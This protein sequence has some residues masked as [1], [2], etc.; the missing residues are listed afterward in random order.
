MSVQSYEDK[1]EYED[2]AK[3]PLLFS[4]MAFEAPVQDSLQPPSSGYQ[5]S[6]SSWNSAHSSNGGQGGSFAPSLAHS[7]TSISADINEAKQ[8]KHFNDAFSQR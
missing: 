3:T 6:S 7:L 4:V 2:E 8:L 1:T 5:D